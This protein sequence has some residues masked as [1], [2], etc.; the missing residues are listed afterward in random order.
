MKQNDY[1][2]IFA[3]SNQFKSAIKII[4][5]S[6]NNAKKISEI[7]N[8]KT[9]KPRT[10]VLRKPRDRSIEDSTYKLRYVLPKDST[11]FA[12]PPVDGFVLQESNNVDGAKRFLRFLTNKDSQTHFTN[13]NYEYQF[14]HIPL[15]LILV[16]ILNKLQSK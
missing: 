3:S 10:F 6:G 5:I 9:P 14:A 1:D 4:R 2:T 15:K 13:I 8:F 16:F 11:I 7:F 12:R